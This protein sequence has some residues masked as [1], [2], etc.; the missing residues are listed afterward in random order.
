MRKWLIQSPGESERVSHSNALFN[1]QR[2]LPIKTGKDLLWWTSDN[3]LNGNNLLLPET[4]SAFV[5][6]WYAITLTVNWNNFWLASSR[7][8]KCKKL[9]KKQNKKNRWNHQH[10][11][12]FF[13]GWFLLIQFYLTT[14]QGLN[15]KEEACQHLQA[16]WGLYKNTHL[17][18]QDKSLSL[19]AFYSIFNS[20]LFSRRDKDDRLFEIPCILPCN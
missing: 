8:Q 18:T 12:Y 17:S 11:K 1:E 2:H 16:T 9:S 20:F 13:S 7:G 4:S 3:Y 10:W 6:Y 15:P 14:K 19:L 5:L